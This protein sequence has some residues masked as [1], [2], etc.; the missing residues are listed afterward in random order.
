MQEKISS[1][2][3]QLDSNKI[4]LNMVIHD[5]RNP[6]SSIKEGLKLALGELMKVQ[7]MCQD[8]KKFS[9]KCQNLNS[10]ILDRRNDSQNVLENNGGK[11]LRQVQS[12]VNFVNE[13]SLEHSIQ[14]DIDN[15]I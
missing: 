5:M 3:K 4:F 7:I 12:C 15:Q 2:G 8:Q 11:K 6:T 13:S 9:D 14:M 1:L 10:K